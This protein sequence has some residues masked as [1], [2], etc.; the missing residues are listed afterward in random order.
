MIVLSAGMQKAGTA[1]YFN[2]TNDLMVAAGHR[3]LRDVR[4]EHKLHAILTTKNGN[5][6]WLDAGRLR[7]LVELSKAGETFTVK[8]HRRPTAAFRRFQAEGHFKS[9]YICRDLRDVIVS[10]LER[11]NQLR[12][13]GEARRYYKVGPYRSFAR[14]KTVEGA[15]IWA[16]WQLMPRWAAWLANE[17][18][19]V[20]RYEDL[21]A[22]P[23][24]E[25]KRLAAHLELDVSATQMEAIIDTYGRK[26]MKPDPGRNLHF[27]KGVSGR[28]REKLT[29]EQQELCLR[30]LGPYLRK[31][32][33]LEDAAVPA[34]SGS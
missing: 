34:L 15:V 3:D 32:G 10:S 4:E 13:S 6:N 30:K 33:Y 29:E 14:L 21:S 1:W 25:L 5:L 7:P 16:R 9:T 28:Y 19:L 31:M 27:N 2:L 22:D 17:Q 18:T 8:T 23:L 20:T 24:K 12:E 26:K 11:G